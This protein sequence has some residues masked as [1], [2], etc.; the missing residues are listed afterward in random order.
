M[1]LNNVCNCFTLYSAICVYIN[2]IKEN[3]LNIIFN[4]DIIAYFLKLPNVS[5]YLI[6]F[7]LYAKMPL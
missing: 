7:Q 4:N 5:V 3:T 6:L 1:I 2:I